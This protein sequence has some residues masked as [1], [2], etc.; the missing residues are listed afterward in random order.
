MHKRA[1]VRE[2][3]VVMRA[4]FIPCLM[5]A[6]ILEGQQPIYWNHGEKIPIYGI[7]ISAPT[8]VV[9]DSPE[10]RKLISEEEKRQDE[11][12]RF[13]R[14]KHTEDEKR[15]HANDLEKHPERMLPGHE[16]FVEAMA[17]APAMTVARKARGKVLQISKA[18]CLPD[19]YST[20]TFI[21]MEVSGKKPLGGTEVWVCE[22]P[23]A[24]GAP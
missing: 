18:R 20:V 21:R 17:K 19:G 6:V 4:S 14:E 23:M 7:G 12:D 11:V 24:F 15:Q 16:E 5:F 2:S 3:M 1:T 9:V 13:Y 8:S 10:V 22:N